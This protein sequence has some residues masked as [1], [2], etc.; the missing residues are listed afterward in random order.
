MSGTLAL[1]SSLASF[2]RDALTALVRGRR[3]AAPTQVVDPID[4]A[5]ELLKP[6]S[7][8]RALAGLTQAELA[9]LYAVASGVDAVHPD[10]LAALGLVG[11]DHGAALALP[12]VSAALT[13]GLAARGLT[14]DSLTHPAADTSAAVDATDEPH[15]WYAQ[16]LTATSQLA[17]VIRELART[18]AKI[19]RGGTISSSWLKSF[20]ERVS[21][22]RID[23]F[24][25]LLRAAGLLSPQGADTTPRARSWLSAPH[26]ERWTVIAEYAIDGA[27]PQLT[28]AVLASRPEQTL[29]LDD[30]DA[31]ASALSERYPLIEETTR[32]DALRV[33][34]VW[35]RLGIVFGGRLSP[36]G[37]AA[38]EGRDPAP[39]ISFP[40]PA[41]GVYIQPD[42]SVVVPGPLSPADERDL[43]SLSVP[44]QIGVASTLRITE[45]SLGDALDR[46]TSVE[47][48]R[49]TLER[50]SLTGIPQPLAYLI[51]SLGERAGSVLVSEHHGDTGRSRIDFARAELRAMIQVDRSLAHLQL[52]EAA[53]SVDTTPSVAPLYSRLRA[54]HVL[55]ALIDAR[56]PARAA[57]PPDAPEA[58]ASAPPTSEAP[59]KARAADS[60][61]PLA[62]LIDRVLEAAAD[63]PGDTVRKLT[64]AIRH[65]RAV[66]VTVEV[67][68]DRREFTLT[69]VSLAAG[70]MRALDEAAGVERTFP[71]DAITE[72]VAPEAH[73]HAHPVN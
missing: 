42:L 38:L 69:P 32:A 48:L 65:R 37:R 4:L 54:D 57:A 53:T 44:E 33:V 68:G 47:E 56:Y 40:P 6:D 29:R 28:D 19:N 59:P 71:L 52:R 36:A 39:H 27:P 30:L 49:S 15:G 64:L 13:A 35:S 12:E 5:V 70:R 73:T 67:R 3:I 21:V 10:R 60:E 43:A 16:A 23:E 7:I 72:V 1:A 50:L 25:P 14:P 2:D 58:P 46:G 18:P 61:D 62:L 24:L 17:W 55:T 31:V 45:A 63:G 9:D 41:P 22:P 20:E 34:G 11:A 66:R 8:S 51:T 26:D